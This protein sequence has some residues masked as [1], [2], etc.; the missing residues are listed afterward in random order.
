MDVKTEKE[1]KRFMETRRQTRKKFN[2]HKDI[3]KK[4]K[5]SSCKH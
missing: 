5:K 3:K 1:G 2:G 4:N